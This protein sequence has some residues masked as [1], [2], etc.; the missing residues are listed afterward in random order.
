MQMATGFAAATSSVPP[1]AHFLSLKQAEAVVIERTGVACAA[2]GRSGG[3]LQAQ[4]IGAGRST[5]SH[6]SAQGHLDAVRPYLPLPLGALAIALLIEGHWPQHRVEAGASED[7]RHLCRPNRPGAFDG[8]RPDLDRRV[9]PDATAPRPEAAAL[10]PLQETGG[11]QKIDGV[12]TTTVHRALARLAGNRPELVH[13]ETV[14][15]DDLQIIALP[16]R[17]THDPSRVGTVA[18]HVKHGNPLPSHA[19]YER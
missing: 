6:P 10:E 11:F 7:L 17:R 14:A 1:V 13:A 9:G 19:H 3:F 4:G 8:L 2:S 12:R 18:A 15:A 16:A 5:V